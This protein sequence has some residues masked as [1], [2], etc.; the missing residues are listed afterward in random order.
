MK[1]LTKKELLEVIIQAINKGR[2]SIASDDI[3]ALFMTN[4]AKYKR[5]QSQ[6]SQI[7]SDRYLQVINDNIDIIYNTYKDVMR[8]PK[9][10]IEPHWSHDE[11]GYY[12]IADINVKENSIERKLRYIVSI[13]F[14]FCIDQLVFIRLD[15]NEPSLRIEL[16]Y[17][18]NHFDL[19]HYSF[20]LP[21][22]KYLKE[23]Y[24]NFKTLDDLSIKIRNNWNI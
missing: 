20:I 3:K 17:D 8:N 14:H 16:N 4:R 10:A 22:F 24:P 6:L 12:D 5:L 7:S 11:L 23:K 2:C 15:I 9:N 21:D 18:C 1:I 19:T 13:K